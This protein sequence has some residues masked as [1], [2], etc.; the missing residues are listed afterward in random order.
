MLPGPPSEM[1][2]L[3]KFAKPPGYSGDDTNVD[4]AEKDD[5]DE[6][7]V[8]LQAEWE[9]VAVT[10]DAVPVAEP[11]VCRHWTSRNL[12]RKHDDS[13]GLEK[14]ECLTQDASWKHAR[15]R[16]NGMA[17]SWAAFGA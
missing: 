8:C 7:A 6:V 4:T 11:D 17:S 1:A 13:E 12:L 16:T 5:A 10:L 2:L 9:K 14:A 3:T 15:A